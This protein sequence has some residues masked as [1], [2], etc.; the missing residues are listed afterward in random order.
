MR[1]MT[2]DSLQLFLP[3]N[4]ALELAVLLINTSPVQAILLTVTAPS[5]RPA[6]W[7]FIGVDPGHDGDFVVNAFR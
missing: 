1:Q 7:A 6:L 3:H 5:K 2:T 4:I